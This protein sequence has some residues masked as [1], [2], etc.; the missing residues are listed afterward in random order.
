MMEY[1]LDTGAITPVDS[2]KDLGV[3]FS[4]KF[5]FIN[6]IESCVAKA[7]SSTAWLFRNFISRE[8]ETIKHLYKSMIR[9]HLEYCPQV[10]APLGRH[11]NWSSIMN[12]E[13]V[14]RWVTSCIQGMDNLSYRQRLDKLGLT[15]LFERRM[16]GDLI[17]VFKTLNGYSSSASNV[18]KQSDRTGNLLVNERRKRCTRSM[19]NDFFGSRVA[20]YWN[21]LPSKV[22]NSTSVN[23]F[24]SNLG[25]FR[26]NNHRQHPFGQFW[27]LSEE[28]FQRIY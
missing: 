4:R 18:L 16:R 6:H 10:W 21:K 23:N 27:E 3:N 7:K 2:E 28:V 12:I 26:E 15:T 20:S 5:S 25:K 14:Q 13:S 8:E 11:G 17:E 24:K 9:P 1:S 19:E 22:K